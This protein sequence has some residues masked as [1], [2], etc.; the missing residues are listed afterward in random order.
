MSRAAGIQ[1]HSHDY[2]HDQGIASTTWT[3]THNL[4][5]RPSITIVDSAG[6]VVQGKRFYVNENIVIVT[7]NSPFTG[8]AYLN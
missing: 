5:R 7:F 6:T 4:N 8:K 3:I 1:N 2:I